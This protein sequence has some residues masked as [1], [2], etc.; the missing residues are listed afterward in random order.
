MIERYKRN[1]KRPPISKVILHNALLIILIS[2]KKSLLLSF[3]DVKISFVKSITLLLF[4][5]NNNSL[6]KERVLS[7]IVSLF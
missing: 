6:Y 4:L 2:F 1:I 5:N 3:P 7:M